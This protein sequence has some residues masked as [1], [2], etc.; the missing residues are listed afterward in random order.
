VK[1]IT[2]I[3]I[4]LAC[5]TILTQGAISHERL[6]TVR[7]SIAMSHFSEEGNLELSGFTLDSGLLLRFSPDRRYFA[8]VTSRG[9]LQSDTVESTIWVFSTTAVRAFLRASGSANGV[10]PHLAARMALPPPE[11]SL[12]VIGNFQ[13]LPNGKGLVFQA[14]SGTSGAYRLYEVDIPSGVVK[15]LS[16]VGYIV[17]DF[18]VAG[19]EI[20]YEA[21][22][23]QTQRVGEPIGRDAVDLTDVTTFVPPYLFPKRSV[24]GPAGYAYLQTLDIN[25]LGAAPSR[26]V[27]HNFRVGQYAGAFDKSLNA[28]DVW[29]FF[30]V[31]PN[32]RYVIMQL[33]VTQDVPS[34]WA[35][36]LPDR[37]QDRIHPPRPYVHEARYRNPLTEYGLLDRVTG[38]TTPLLSAPLATPVTELYTSGAIWSRTGNAVLL[39]NVFLPQHHFP[40]L[41][42]VVNIASRAFS[43]VAFSSDS[44]MR[45]SP[46][47]DSRM[48]VVN[49]AFGPTTHDIVLKVM[50]NSDPGSQ[51]I[52]GMSGWN[53][54]KYYYHFSG[55]KWSLRNVAQIKQNDPVSAEGPLAITVR[56]DMNTPPTL[57]ATDHASG[58]SKK[59]WDP[60]PQLAG[61][62]LGKVSVFRWRDPN[63]YE[64]VAGLVLPPNYIAGRRY[65]LV[66]QTHG[67]DQNRFLSDGPFASVF[68]A[69]PLASA[70]IIVLQ[71]NE[72]LD[73]ALSPQE[74]PDNVP[75]IESAITRL[76]ALGFIDPK[77]VGATGWSRT[78]FY[79][80]SM[81]V[82]HPQLLAAASMADSTTGGYFQ[83]LFMGATSP[84]GTSVYGAPPFGK[85]LQVWIKKA[86]TFNLDR[87]RTPL[88]ISSFGGDQGI[89]NLVSVEWEIYAQ[90]RYQNKPVDLMSIPTGHHVL[91]KPWEIWASEQTNV[92]WYR[93]WLQG[94]EDPD[95]AKAAQYRRWED[96]RKLQQANE[97]K[98][99]GATNQ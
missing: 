24:S 44:Y 8:V 59:I 47:Y 78:G 46:E 11:F 41:A 69:R 40:C 64:E 79:I 71:M 7:D 60:N 70:G 61:M 56:Q 45:N 35:S 82:A 51:S 27:S 12:Q 73:H 92:D 88:L 98:I 28:V 57:W 91:V 53:Y 65:P 21:V 22:P 74:L 29:S 50:R 94:Y 17:N 84:D 42:V 14:A 83:E 31:A 36:F 32:G 43:C 9:I 6:F 63:G 85:G 5:I 18:A 95:P 19:H 13:W 87:V 81:M 20:M 15:P 49:A 1:N 96:L 38:R 66:I 52:E 58:I 23:L 62:N 97:A 54:S 34:S 10:Q 39:L 55:S 25:T 99:T 86:P 33:P 37:P 90:L 3:F 89:G 16:P 4:A 80:E 72:N 77:R 2:G 67:F 68:A 93:F 75:A 30:S 48:E 76:D 26:D